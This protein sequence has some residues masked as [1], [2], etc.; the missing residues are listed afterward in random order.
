M[1]FIAIC[2]PILPEVTVLIMCVY[3][4]SIAPCIVCLTS[5]HDVS[6]HAV[7]MWHHP[8][9]YTVPISVFTIFH[10]HPPS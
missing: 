4:L 6:S 7:Y 10:G 9:T 2:T 3:N 5:A 1:I 8:T